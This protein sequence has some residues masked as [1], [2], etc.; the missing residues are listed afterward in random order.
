MESWSDGVMIKTILV[1]VGFC[2]FFFSILQ[3]SITPLIFAE[4]V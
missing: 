2:M 4:A 1:S 3:Y